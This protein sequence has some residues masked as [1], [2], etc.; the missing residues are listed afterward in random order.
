MN[1][2]CWRILV[3]KCVGDK[4]GQQH[5]DSYSSSEHS[6]A[7]EIRA[8]API[9]GSCR[10]KTFHIH[11]FRLNKLLIY[12]NFK[13]IET[14]LNFWL[15]ILEITW[16]EPNSQIEFTNYLVAF[17]FRPKCMFKNLILL[18]YLGSCLIYMHF[19][20]ILGPGLG[21]FLVPN[22]SKMMNFPSIGSGRKWADGRDFF[23]F[24]AE[25]LWPRP[26]IA[27]YHVDNCIR[28][29]PHVKD[30]YVVQ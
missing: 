10:N 3:I 8:A 7:W 21:P 27:M 11:S 9:F 12:F 14:V 22:P 4:S 5:L 25:T 6:P 16:I 28:S 30:E 13:P 19:R 23:E 15:Q 24:F 26:L 18:R 29:S 2:C 1:R 20:G 17:N